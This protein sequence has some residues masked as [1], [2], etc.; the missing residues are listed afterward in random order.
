ME[1]SICLSVRFNM[2]IKNR[3]KRTMTKN[4]V[5]KMFHNKLNYVGKPPD[6]MHML[7]NTIGWHCTGVCFS[8]LSR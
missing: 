4:Y 6:I 5:K 3:E 8:L 2:S 7:Y 1:C